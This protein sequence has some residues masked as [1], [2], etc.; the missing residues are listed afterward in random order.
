MIHLPFF[1]KKN[2]NFEIVPSKLMIKFFNC[3]TG[4]IITVFDTNTSTIAKLYF[5]LSYQQ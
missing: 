4:K 2:E 5:K 3:D 1:E